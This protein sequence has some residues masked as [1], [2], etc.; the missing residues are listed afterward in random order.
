[1]YVV[2]EVDDNDD[3]GVIG[4]Y[5]F[6]NEVKWYVWSRWRYEYLYCLLERC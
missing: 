5:K 4:L 1:M 6:L 2:E 3:D